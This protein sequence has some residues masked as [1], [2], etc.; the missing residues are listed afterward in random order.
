MCFVFI[1]PIHNNAIQF[2]KRPG[3]STK[4]SNACI[5]YVQNGTGFVRIWM[6]YC[7]Q[8]HE[9]RLYVAGKY[10]ANIR[11]RLINSVQLSLP[12]WLSVATLH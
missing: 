1:I 10:S 5:R 2:N 9:R 4:T 11:K 12:P 7:V 8:L 3:K 6:F